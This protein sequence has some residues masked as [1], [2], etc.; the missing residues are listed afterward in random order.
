[1]GRKTVVSYL[2]RRSKLLNKKVDE[3]PSSERSS[4]ASLDSIF[5]SD[6]KQKMMPI[7]TPPPS[8]PK[9]KLSLDS[10]KLGPSLSQSFSTLSTTVFTVAEVLSA[11]LP[12]PGE[13]KLGGSLESILDRGTRSPL[14]PTNTETEMETEIKDDANSITSKS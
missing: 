2:K 11:S 12:S 9:A 3:R 7:A 6:V 14:R 5:F 8:P 13:D 10:S 1:M 4:T